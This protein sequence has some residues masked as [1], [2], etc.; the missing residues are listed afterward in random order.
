MRFCDQVCQKKVWKGHKPLCKALGAASTTPASNDDDEAQAACC[1]IVDGLGALGSDDF[2]TEAVQGV[3]KR[4]KIDTVTIHA[5]RGRNVADQL[6]FVLHPQNTQTAHRFTSCIILGWGSGHDH[7]AVEFGNSRLLQSSLVQWVRS[8]GRFLAHGERIGLCGN[9]PRE[10]FQLA[11]ESSSYYRTS[12][13][14][15]QESHWASW[16]VQHPR[17]ARTVNVKACLVTGVQ[18]TDMLYGTDEE[19]TTYSLVPQMAGRSI[20]ANQ[21]AFTL[22]RYGL[23]S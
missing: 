12:H 18:A 14:L 20:G 1:L 23:G 2:L 11:W 4:D 22:A 9:W 21:S 16:F 6:R 7:L 19:S 5:D 17:A 15:N 13:D 8:G 10:W 3:L